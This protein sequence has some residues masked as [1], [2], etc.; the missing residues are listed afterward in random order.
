M[1]ITVKRGALTKADGAILILTH[2][3]GNGLRREGASINKATGGMIQEV[4]ASEEFSGK[5]L[6]TCL[7]RT[8]GK[9]RVPRLLLLGL[10]KRGEMTLDRIRQAMARAATQAR[11]M[12]LD[13]LL[14]P[15]HGKDLDASI[16]DLTQAMIEGVHLGLYQFQ[17]YKTD[18]PASKGI[19]NC[20]LIDT[21]G[22]ALA[23][24]RSGADRG[25]RI[26]EAVSYVRDL[27][28]TP[29]NMATPSHLAEEA[30]RIATEYG[31]NVEVYDRP[32][33]ERLG[34]GA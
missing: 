32:D 11:E 12:G 6:Q 15:V 29:S 5:F 25:K 14:T 2:Y 18:R 33:I 13:R 4:I 3:E 17:I 7:L 20:T 1:E 22:K 23:E 9:I 26:A 28:N 31:M 19:K 24:I 16:R 8:Y 27:C 21:D 10:G 30:K 34:M